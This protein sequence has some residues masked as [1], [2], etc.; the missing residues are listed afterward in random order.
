MEK[1][2]PAVDNLLIMRE[3]YL[4]KCTR[5]ELDSIDQSLN[6]VRTNWNAVTSEF[7]NRFTRYEKAVS[8]WRQFNSDLKELTIWLTKA[9]NKLADTKLANGEINEE[10]A[11]QQQ[12][13]CKDISY[14]PD[15]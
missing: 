4:S 9:E 8:V 6:L 10:S 1:I 12:E 13:V 11:K 2:A 15:G 3:K 5:N 7:R 14:A